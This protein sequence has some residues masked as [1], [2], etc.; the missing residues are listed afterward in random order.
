[1][2]DPRIDMVYF[3]FLNFIADIQTSDTYDS[4]LS[5]LKNSFIPLL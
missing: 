1:M 4:H 5:N 3:I 2:L